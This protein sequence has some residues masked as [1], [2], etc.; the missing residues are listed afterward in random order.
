MFKKPKN[1][2]GSHKPKTDFR[3]GETGKLKPKSFPNPPLPKTDKK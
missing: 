1:S 2:S 3:S